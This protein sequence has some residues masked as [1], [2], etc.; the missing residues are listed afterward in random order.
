MNDAE[1]S[2]LST[3]RDEFIEGEEKSRS[4]QVVSKVRFLDH[5]HR[6]VQHGDDVESVEE[7]MSDPEG[8]EE[9]D[10]GCGCCKDVDDA[11]D[12]HE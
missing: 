2:F 9:V 1:F 8:A 7:F 5:P 10:S 3:K 6:P 12:D 11:D 4:N